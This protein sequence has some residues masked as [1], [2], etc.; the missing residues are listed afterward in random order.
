MLINLKDGEASPFCFS[1]NFQVRHMF[2]EEMISVVRFLTSILRVLHEQCMFPTGKPNFEII[3]V[4]CV[5]TKGKKSDQYF[6][7]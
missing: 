5:K 4:L 6:F 1:E 7:L 3:V 2:R